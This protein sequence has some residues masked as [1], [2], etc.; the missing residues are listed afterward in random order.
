LR[1]AALEPL[2]P[3]VQERWA[4]LSG[5][6][7]STALA[8]AGLF[9]A[10][11]VLQTAL[12]AAAA[13]ALANDHHPP[14]HPQVHKLHRH[15]AQI[16]VA[17]AARALLGESGEEIAQADGTNGAQAHDHRAAPMR[18][19][20]CLD[21]LRQA[22]RVLERSANAVTEDPVVVWQ[23]QES[24]AGI[25]DSSATALAADLIALAL[26]EIATLTKQRIAAH[27]LRADAASAEADAADTHAAGHGEQSAAATLAAAFDQQVRELAAPAGIDA[28]SIHRLLPMAATVAQLVA[29]EILSALA[30]PAG[31]RAPDGLRQTLRQALE[32]SIPF[33]DQ[34]AAI[35]A[36]TL[37]TAA[38]LVRSG[39]IA[40][41]AGVELPSVVARRSERTRTM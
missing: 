23:T 22:A 31:P 5:T 21:L 25:E 1:R 3:A 40:R 26:R 13:S 36:V 29:L 41:A 37:G 33:A 24:V 28:G 17:A 4:L 10:E 7:L 2:K 34:A 11:R 32:E 9:E 18:M 39:A 19:G 35:S 6:Q 27:P 16:E 30:P 20:A 12:V 8:L 38:E 14:L 15:P